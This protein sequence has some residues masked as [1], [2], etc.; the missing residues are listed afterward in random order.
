MD[1]LQDLL[2]NWGYLGFLGFVLLGNLG[3]PIPEE[4]VLWVAGYLVWKDGF[5]L[6]LVLLVG[7]V[8]AVL[9]DNLGFYLGRR[10][11]QGAVERFKFWFLPT[12]A[13]VERM[14]QVVIRYGPLG[15]FLARFVVG[16]RFLAG[17]IA[18]SLKLPWRSFFVA[19]VLG[20]LCYVPIMVGAG[21]AVGYGLGDTVQRVQVWVSRVEHS[22]L[23]G[24][25]LCGLLFLAY[26]VL[27]RR[28][29]LRDA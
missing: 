16:W 24:T 20:A 21:Y 9:G 3:L 5:S 29:D 18:G 27:Q 26:R 19:N 2:S 10:Y 6:P 1:S 4:W 22:L 17:P 8:G 14:R 15:V 13:R 12:P 28:L 11:G 23:A 25:Q 7:I